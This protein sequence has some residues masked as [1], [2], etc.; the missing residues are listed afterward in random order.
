M[1]LAIYYHEKDNVLTCCT[2]I[3]KGSEI[4]VGETVICAQEDIPIYHKIALCDIPKGEFVYKYGEP[5]G[6]ASHAI[7]KGY[8]VHTQNLESAR[9]RKERKKG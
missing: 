4:K 3:K 1:S 5:I 9:G 7:K 2:E 6:V 8:H